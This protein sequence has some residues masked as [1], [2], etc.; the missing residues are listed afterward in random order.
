LE[1]DVEITS[2]YSA[3]LLEMDEKDAQQECR[4][5]ILVDKKEWERYRGDNRTMWE[6]ILKQTD[7]I[8]KLRLDLQRE[9]QRKAEMPVEEKRALKKEI[10]RLKAEKESIE[11]MGK[12]NAEFFG[13]KHMELMRLANEDSRKIKESFNEGFEKAKLQYEENY[14]A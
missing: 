14:D 5:R 9:V 1:D 11:E 10:C 6:K 8:L 4:G 2:D 3:H 7:D 12:R 13:E